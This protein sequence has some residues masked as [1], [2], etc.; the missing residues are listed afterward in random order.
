MAGDT[1]V[2]MGEVAGAYGVSGALRIRPY[3]AAPETLLGFAAWWL[4]PARGLNWREFARTDGRAHS[5]AL[6]AR[7]AGIETRE[8][9]LAMK[10]ASVGVP[11]NALPAAA[12][13]EIYWDDLVGLAVS[14]RAGIALGV[15]VGLSAHGA[16]PL[17]RLARPAGERG[18]E[19]LIP[20]VPAIIRRVDVETGRIE[21]DWEADY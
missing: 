6:I 9:A 14:N 12:E 3:T 19:R 4:K 15:V 21:V 8:A 13:D 5:G 18:P 20:Y 11:R 10:G 2:V 7:L 17:L 1:I 16:H